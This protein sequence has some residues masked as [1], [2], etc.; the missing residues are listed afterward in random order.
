VQAEPGSP[1][2]GL[3]VRVG[4][5][6]ALIAAAVGLRAGSPL[7]ADGTRWHLDDLLHRA[8][9]GLEIVLGLWVLVVLV[10]ILLSRQDGP[11]APRVRRN[12]IVSLALLLLG[13]LAALIYRR[14]R[15]EPRSIPSSPVGSA[16]PT[17]AA[18]HVAATT[19][20]HHGL[21]LLLLLG[22]VAVLTALVRSRRQAVGVEEA[23]EADPTAGGLLA[24]ARSFRETVDQEPRYRVVLAYAAFEEALAQEGVARGP[25]G[26]PDALLQ[27]AVAVGAPS[28]PAQDLT[29]LF[30]AARFGAEPVTARDVRAAER[31]LDE[32]LAVR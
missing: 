31:A 1:L 27:R 26:T 14:F 24:A 5:L 30:G 25:S 12:P 15:G 23:P 19:T 20:G 3:L 16:S 9:S 17:P 4:V 29:R 6:G 28:R 32:L 13:V 22:T 18:H 8:G 7:D 2:R 10:A 21:L 11:P